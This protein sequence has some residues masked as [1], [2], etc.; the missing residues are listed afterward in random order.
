[1]SNPNKKI[2][3]LFKG[4]GVELE[5]MIV[6][7]DTLAIKP[8]AD[9]LL[10]DMA[11]N[12]VA[13]FENG[14]IA[15]SNE[16]VL[17]VLEIKTNGPAP[18]LAGL[19]KKFLANITMANKHLKKY[20]A[21]LMPTGAHPFMDPH[22]ETNIWPHEYNEV[23]ELYNRIFNCKG[24]GWSNLQSTHINLPFANDEEF[25][26]LHAAIRLIL[27]II[28]ALS[29]STPILD[30]KFQGLKDHRLDYYRKNQ[31]K[32]PEIAGKVIPERV[33][34]QAEYEKQIFEPIHK[35]IL[36]YD[37]DGVLD[38]YFLNSRGA[39]ARFDRMAIEIRIIDI[40]ECPK[41]DLAIL[42]LIVETIKY[43]MNNSQSIEKQMDWSENELVSIFVD[44][45]KDA[46]ETFIT[47]ANYLTLFDYPFPTAI[48]QHL[49]KHIVKKLNF[50]S[51]E[52]D[53][54]LENGSLATRMLEFMGDDF[55]HE[56]IHALSKNL[57]SCLASNTYFIPK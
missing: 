21:M 28:P 25:K 12:V 26:K 38:K 35:A 8:I 45:Y 50:H 40:Q 37:K 19:H 48:A 7:C 27:P 39:I 49:W 24:H 44:C 17:H 23:Y 42:E 9:K 20:N 3:S 52:I 29:A 30:S 2:L 34:S 55:S 10:E 46:E 16:L 51:P 36:P 15:W 11:G 33:I 54:L 32:I 43:I 56:R 18:A 5:Y 41:M 47:N 14:E 53:F 57:S 22:K 31:S 1:M 4:F 13:D 6:D